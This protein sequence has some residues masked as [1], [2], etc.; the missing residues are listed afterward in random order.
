ME[1]IKVE[2]RWSDKNFC[3]GWALEGVG[4][5]MATG[6]TLSEL[7]QK[8]HDALSF[9]V[10]GMQE[11]GEK[12]PQWLAD[13]DYIIEYDLDTTALIRYSEEF[14]TMAAISRASGINARLLSHYANGIKTPRE[15][16][17]ARIIE[18]LHKIGQ[19]CMALS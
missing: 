16:Q 17:R 6:K 4:A 14:T 2:V 11:D 3:C 19:A 18:G 8:F 5:V 10:E 12:L 13:G 7:K 15:K 1:K 9:H